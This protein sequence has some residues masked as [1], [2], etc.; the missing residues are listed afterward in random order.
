MYPP[1]HLN[2]PPSGRGKNLM[3]RLAKMPISLKE[4]GSEQKPGNLG[5]CFRIF[6]TDAGPGVLQKDQ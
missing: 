1:T 3:P 5:S 6:L 4:T 2:A